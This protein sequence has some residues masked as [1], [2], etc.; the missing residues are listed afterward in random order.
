MTG[1]SDRLLRI[2]IGDDP[3][4]RLDKALGRHAPEQAGLSRT[5]LARLIAEGAVSRD[6]EV[7]TDP[8]RKTAP[9]EVWTIRL[10]EAGEIAAEPEAIALDV[11]YED[12][13]LIVVNKPA[14]MVVHPAPGAWTG[15]LVN[16]LLAHC[17]DSLSGIGGARRPGIVH[18]IDKDTSG[19]LVAAKTDRAHQG[20][21]AQFAA[22]DVE[23]HYRAVCHGVPDRADPRLAG[24][25]GVGF[26]PGGVT[27]VA[28]AIARHRTDRQ[29][30]AVTRSGG[31]RAV[32]RFR[33]IAAFARA[34]ALLDC[35][36]ETG[37]THQVRVHLAHLGHGLIGDP[38]YGRRR[39][40]AAGL[41][42]G[43]AAAAAAFPRQALHA[44]TL[45]FRH[46]VTDEALRFEAPLPPDMA[47]LV[48]ALSGQGGPAP[49]TPPS[50]P[51]TAA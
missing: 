15:T 41:P 37:R 17:G 6:G 12:A 10:P 23:R 45:G 21:A 5:R 33:V 51:G 44:A 32:T 26:E 48:A 18:R 25:A 7:V 34:A 46:P 24:M 38:V 3:P 1:P 30:M 49:V 40:T 22:H 35:W 19:L 42:P 50:R 29:R 47:A 4:E 2:E 39:L 13:E 31:R 27:R 8:R 20:L 28:L 16:A 11:V 36:L 14:G 43:A 9:G